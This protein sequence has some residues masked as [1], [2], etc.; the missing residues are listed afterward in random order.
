MGDIKTFRDLDIWNKGIL[1][2]EKIYELTESFPSQEKFGLCSQ[3]RRA[4]VSVPSNVAEGFRRRHKKEFQQFLNISMGSLAEIETQLVISSKL[5]YISE[6]EA[7]DM[8]EIIDHICRMIVNL[9][10][11]L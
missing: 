8:Y 2:V 3:I 10:K 1:L 7:E 9:M 11:K 4:A 5:N 6:V